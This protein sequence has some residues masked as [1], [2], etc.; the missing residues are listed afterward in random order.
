MNLSIVDWFGYNLPPQERMRLIKEAGFSGIIGFMWTDMFDANYKKFPEYARNAG[1]HIENIH[2][3]W[4]KANEL[5]IDNLDGQN[6]MEEII[7]NIK[8]CSSFEIPT[9]VMHPECKSGIEYAELP[10]D[11]NIGLERLKR[12]TDIAEQFNINI[13]IENM[14]RFEY[15][16]VIF[17]NIKS[18]KLGF[19]F[20]S[21]HWNL[22]MNEHDLLTLYGNKLMALHLHDND[23]LDDWHSLPFSGSIDWKDIKTKLKS[24]D[25]KGSIALEVGNK[26][27]EHIKEPEKFLQIAVERAKK[28]ITM[29]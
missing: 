5:W 12:I 11:F 1:L 23:G 2:A 4:A 7:E 15:L 8:V 19:C 17:K 29:N 28:L 9:I 6:F 27:F 21:G 16:D 13:A 10:D 18:N 14:A 3:M 20:D 24:V 22:F 26:N 25:Y